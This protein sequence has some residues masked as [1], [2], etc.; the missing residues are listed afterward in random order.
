MNTNLPRGFMSKLAREV[1]DEEFGPG[2]QFLMQDAWDALTP[3]TQHRLRQAYETTDRAQRAFA[4]AIGTS[5]AG[6]RCVK[7]A[8]NLDSVWV[9]E[10]NTNRNV[11]HVGEKEVFVLVGYTSDDQALYRNERTGELGWITWETL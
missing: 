7:K 3:D 5:Y 8:R 10:P 6:M 9:Y 4:Q 11:E 1:I 2:R